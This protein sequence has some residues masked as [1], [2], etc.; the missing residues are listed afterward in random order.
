[1]WDGQERRSSASATARAVVA[2]REQAA[3]IEAELEELRS[4]RFAPRRRVSELERDLREIRVVEARCLE[5][6][7]ASREARAS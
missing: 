1:M 2:A 3:A 7:G 5:A 4:K 6:L